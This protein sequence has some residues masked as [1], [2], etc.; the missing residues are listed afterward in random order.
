MDLKEL[1]YVYV[2]C[3]QPSHDEPSGYKKGGGLFDY[4]R[5]C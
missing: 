2:D 1:L 3:I 5:H 4:L